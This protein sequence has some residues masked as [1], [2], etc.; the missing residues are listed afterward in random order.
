VKKK[1][2]RNIVW[3]VVGVFVLS[4][5]GYYYFTDCLP[6]QKRLE[7]L[8]Q[9]QNKKGTLTTYIA[10]EIIAIN[11]IHNGDWPVVQWRWVETKEDYF[12]DKVLILDSTSNVMISSKYV[13][14]D[15]QIFY[16]KEG[17]DKVTNKEYQFEIYDI[18][19]KTAKKLHTIDVMQV[20][21]QAGIQPGHIQKS[22]AFFGNGEY[23]KV[24]NNQENPLFIELRT[25]KIYKASEKMLT[26]D[27][28]QPSASYTINYTNF[29]KMHKNYCFPLDS[30]F[31][32]SSKINTKKMYGLTKEYSEVQKLLEAT[33][34]ENTRV[35]VNYSQNPPTLEE[36]L[37]LII[38]VG[39]DP[40]KELKTNG[41]EAI[42]S[43]E[44]LEQL[45]NEYNEK[46][47]QEKKNE[48]D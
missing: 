11:H 42:T 36:L 22:G 44:Q 43:Y 17:S 33:E 39:E 4:M 34:G 41:G 9:D 46:L 24:V 8:E 30:C 25:G 31:T 6:E 19:G 1:V 16:E 10:P 35:T 23:I 5:G 21:K 20:Y 27:K 32:L 7:Y 40:L 14:F 38:P 12:K 3:I 18:Q 28:E 2:R 26:E 13:V 29:E 47:K 45:T 48:E 37:K 15:P